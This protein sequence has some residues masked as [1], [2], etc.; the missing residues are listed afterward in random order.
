MQRRGEL[1]TLGKM[2]LKTFLNTLLLVLFPIFLFYLLYTNWFN[3]RLFNPFETLASAFL[4]GRVDLGTEPFLDT[5]VFNGR[6]YWHQGPLPAILL[7][8]YVLLSKPFPFGLVSFFLTLLTA[9]TLY[10]LAHRIFK[11]KGVEAW[12]WVFLYLFGSVFTGVSFEAINWYY[13]QIVAALFVLLALREYFGKRRFFL[14]GS[15]L[16]L[17]VA[18]RNFSLLGVVFFAIVIVFSAD[19]LKKKLTH[20]LSLG[21]PLFTILLLL[22]IYNFVRF[23]SFSETGYSLATVGEQESVNRSRKE[24]FFHLSHIP[25]N[26]YWYFLKGPEG[27][28]SG[29]KDFR[30]VFPFVIPSP[31]GMSLF[32]SMPFFFLA[33][34]KRPKGKEE[35][36]LLLT[37][38]VFMLFLLSYYTTGFRQYSSRLIND[39]LPYWFV[40]LLLGREGKNL[41]SKEKIFIL[42]SVLLNLYL[43]TVFK[44]YLTPGA[45]KVYE[46]VNMMPLGK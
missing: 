27:V 16:G 4:Q 12:W 8:P 46:R 22:G 33:F 17:A 35:L 32:I 24:G 14:I 23:G 34:T 40:L 10:G 19:K 41:S 30:T 31:W 21:I 20:L 5:A 11:K 6:V 36:G 42:C 44:W 29:D 25:T 38:L 2:S 26:F 3:S 13:A 1:S 37:V 28:T 9:F 15:F 7:V 43:F 18:T 39:L 45:G